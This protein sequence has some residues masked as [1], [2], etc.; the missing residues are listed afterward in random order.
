M[1]EVVSEEE[2]DM[3]VVV[4]VLSRSLMGILIANAFVGGGGV[5]SVTKVE[6][7]DGSR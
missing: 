2:Y 3:E 1:S 6:M 7:G 4:M 5:M